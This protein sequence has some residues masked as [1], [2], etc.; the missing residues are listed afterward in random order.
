[1][2]ASRLGRVQCL[3]AL[4]RDFGAGVNVQVSVVEPD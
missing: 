3:T 1:M 4:I 2:M